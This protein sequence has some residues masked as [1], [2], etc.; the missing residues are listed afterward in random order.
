M[1]DSTSAPIVMQAKP[2]WKSKRF[3]LGAIHIVGGIVAI[4]TLGASIPGAA[5]ISGVAQIVLGAVS[6]GPITTSTE[7]AEEINE[8]AGV[9]ASIGS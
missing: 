2:W 3:W 6:K 5:I 7:K 1:S 9:T 8:Q 4:P